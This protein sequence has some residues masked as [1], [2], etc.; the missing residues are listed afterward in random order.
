MDLFKLVNLGDLQLRI[1]HI[2]N[3][4]PMEYFDDPVLKQAFVSGNKLLTVIDL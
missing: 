2:V 4:T 3:N 1:S